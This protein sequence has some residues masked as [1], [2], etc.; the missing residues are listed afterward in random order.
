VGC[1]KIAIANDFIATI[2]PEIGA[3]DPNGAEGG[4]DLN[5]DGDTLDYVVRWVQMAPTSVLPLTSAANLHALTDVPGGTH[6]LAELGYRFVI[7]VSEAQD[8]RD[9]DGDGAMT[10]DLVGWL[11][12]TGSAGTN[13]PWNFTHVLSNG[14]LAYA[15]ASWM[16]EI[17]DRIRVNVAFEESVRHV[18]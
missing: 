4:C 1:R 2:T 18:D 17:P 5:G 9:I 10:H 15:G 7:E 14:G 12:P 13:T 3:A 8:N 6:G 11:Q 16:A